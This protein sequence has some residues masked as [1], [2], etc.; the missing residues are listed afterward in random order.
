MGKGE[1]IAIQ[2]EH[3]DMMGLQFKE[4]TKWRQP[5]MKNHAV[6]FGCLGAD[7]YA[8]KAWSD[9]DNKKNTQMGWATRGKEVKCAVETSPAR[10]TALRA[11]FDAHED[12]R[13]LNKNINFE[14][15]QRALELWDN[16]GLVRVGYFS[17]GSER[18][19]WDI[20]AAIRC[21]ISLPVSMLQMDPDEPNATT[22]R[23][24]IAE[25]V[26]AQGDL[27]PAQNQGDDI[28]DEFLDDDDKKDQENEKKHIIPP[29]L[30]PQAMTPL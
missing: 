11:F 18:W 22:P 1:C 7:D 5:F 10:R 25:G 4:E 15:C 23:E 16:T 24:E 26:E 6:S 20:A 8:R 17:K 30:R 28:K 3:S 21:S 29:A 27:P 14:E 19:N 13:S 9:R 12:L 2:L